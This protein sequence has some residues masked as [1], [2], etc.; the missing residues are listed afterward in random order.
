MENGRLRAT[1]AEEA[2]GGRLQLSA[3]GTAATAIAAS[4]ASTSHIFS[5]LVQSWWA[6]QLSRY[7][8]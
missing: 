4:T 8:D 3:T 7:S 5:M 6:G 2:V 1:E